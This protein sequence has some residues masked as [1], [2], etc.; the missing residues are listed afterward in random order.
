MGTAQRSKSLDPRPL[1]CE[2]II[3]GTARCRSIP[4]LGFLG[5]GVA[6]LA[7]TWNLYWGY[8]DYDGALTEL[9]VARQTLPND[10][11]SLFCTRQ[12]VGNNLHNCAECYPTKKRGHIVG[13][14][15]DATVA[16]WAPDHFLLGRAV[17]VNASAESMRVG[18]FQTAQP[19]DAGDDGITPRRIRVE[20][21]AGPVAIVKHGSRGRVVANF[22]H[23]LQKPKRRCHPS[24][25]IA[26][27]EFGSGNGIS[28]WLHAA[29]DKH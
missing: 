16:G 18:H 21:F 27:T 28:D 14:H 4:Q 13:P 25:I 17:N 6:G 5:D 8:L 29:L 15:S 12:M 26:Q 1:R 20:N 23:D 9:E 11:H 7:R 22:L 10:P 24:A 2:R 3:G 19:N